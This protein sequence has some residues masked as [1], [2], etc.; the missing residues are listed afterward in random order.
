MELSH[1]V[2]PLEM[3][4]K[5]IGPNEDRL[6]EEPTSWCN[7][8]QIEKPLAQFYCRLEIVDVDNSIS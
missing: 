2:S 8:G 7:K 3:L 5:V 1:K 4:V 6:E